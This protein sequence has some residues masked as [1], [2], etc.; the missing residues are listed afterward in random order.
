MLAGGRTT[1]AVALAMILLAVALLP[2]PLPSSVAP[3]PAAPLPGGLGV[4]PPRLDGPS[5]TLAGPA[6]HAANAAHV[7]TALHGSHVPLRYAYLPNFNAQVTNRGGI[8]SPTYLHSPAPY[9]IA[10]YGVENS[11]GNATPYILNSPSYEGAITFDALDE[12]Y[13][14]DDAPDYIGAQLNTVVSNVTLFGATNYSFWNQNVVTYSARSHLLQFIDNIWNFSSPAF[15]LTSNVFNETGPNGSLIAPVFYYALGPVL[16]VSMPFTLHLFLNATTTNVGGFPDDM[17]FFNYTVIKSGLTLAA[18]TFDWVV[19]NSQD[20]ANPRA[21]IPAPMYQTNGFAPTPTGYLPY[22]SELVFCGPGG[23]STTTVRN[24]NATLNL[25]YLNTSTGTYQTVPSAYAY[26]TNT[27]ETIEGATEWYDAA[28]TVHVGPGP[29]LPFPLWNGSSTSVPGDLT[30]QGTVAPDTSFVFWNAS[31]SFN[32]TW[33]AWAPVPS[34]GIVRYEM[35]MGDYVGEVLLANF[36][37]ASVVVHGAVPSTWTLSIALTANASRGIYTPLIAFDDTQLAELAVAG[38][39][40]PSAPYLLPN[41]AAVSLDPIFGSINDFGFPVFPGLLLA[42]TSAYVVLNNSST[43]PIDYGGRALLYMEANGLPLS[44]HLQIELYG[45]AHVSL[46]NTTGISGWFDGATLTGFPLASVMAWNTSSTLLAANTFSSQGTSALFYGGA[47]NTVWGNRFEMDPSLSDPLVADALLAGTYALG[48]QLF[49]SGDLIADNAFLTQVPASSPAATIYYETFYSTFNS[50][51]TNTWNVSPQPASDVLLVNGIP[52]SGSVVGGNLEAGNLWWDYAPA[53]SNLPYNDS[54]GIAVGGDAFPLVG[55]LVTFTE[56]GLAPGTPWA[57]VLGGNLVTTADAT[58]VMSWLDGTIAYSVLSVA[59]YTIATSNGSLVLAGGPAAVAVAFTLVPAL[60][61]LSFQEAGLPASTDWWVT[62][63]GVSRNST[64]SVITFAIAN[65]TYSWSVT[66]VVGVALETPAGTVMIAGADRSIDVLFVLPSS[67]EFVIA[68]IETG[69]PAGTLWSA[70]VGG[71]TIASQL[72]T[73]TFEEPNGSYGIALDTVSGYS[74]AALP[75]AV[76][77][78]GSPVTVVV[79]FSALPQLLVVSVTPTSG[80][81]WVDRASV[82]V[83]ANGTSRL[84]V[85][86]GLHAIEAAAA[87]FYPK[88]DNVTVPVGNLSL[89]TPAILVVISLDP[90]GSTSNSPAGLSGP[91]LALLGGVSL[92]ALVF[93]IGLVYFWSRARSA[94]AG[95][96]PG[97]GTGGGPP[98]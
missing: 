11:T 22:E 92:L 59:G 33:A 68:V 83:A 61:L 15:E 5:A 53:A 62:L 56:T 19:F 36:D 82:P 65:G 64:T 46:T 97:A 32:A 77:I 39:G 81:L 10:S 12:F 96:G 21:T 14:D 30:I 13:L 1:C 89:D 40:T 24:L 38:S 85:T 51:W 95:D 90:I 84:V 2:A 69:L 55:D 54:G 79:P 8:V 41:D 45:T 16:N 25:W 66:P 31:S 94:S 7:L 71:T 86:P 20:P 88:F 76:T 44:N 9:G 67:I 35:P 28:N 57:F 60:Y 27:G 63:N 91:D 34:G 26:G 78:A 98:R 43:F 52:L 17:V 49:E 73:I 93:L 70:T 75:P 74:H 47:G 42:H 87:G 4:S 50:S 23:G 80:Q 37:P 48:P 72:D 18:G 3:T 58:V 6:P 29:T